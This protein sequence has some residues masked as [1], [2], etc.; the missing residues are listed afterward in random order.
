M[1]SAAES[2]FV[3]VD[4]LRLHYTEQGSGEPVLFL[5]GWPTSSYLW[6]N[7]MPAVAEERRAIALDMPGYGA[8]EKP[9]DASYSF[10][11][12]ERAVDGFLDA[13]G[14][15][16]TGLVVHDV[17][18]PIGLYWASQHPERLERLALL[19][20]L[21]FSK[22][23]WA[24]V[25]FIAA[26]KV[27]GVR[28]L[29]T[30]P[31]GIK[32]ALRVGVRDKSKLTDEVVRAYQQPFESKESQRVLAKAGTSLHPD[33][34]KTIESWL[35]QVSVPVRLLYGEKDRILP[36]VA[37]TMNRV[38]EL[39]PQAELSTLPDCGHFC[40]EERPDEIGA[41]LSAFFSR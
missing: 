2:R 13:L 14:I 29:L 31:S 12:F 7:V 25:A 33:G 28:G 18:G 1:S 27:P 16:R 22:L 36:D 4:G 24:A 17:G 6:R 8:S 15:G 23:S 26:A 39:L 10:R 34:L 9:L 37:R 40:Q 21:V 3:E 32:R 38:A 41:A 19:N 30:S 20:T 5:H 11:F 35:P